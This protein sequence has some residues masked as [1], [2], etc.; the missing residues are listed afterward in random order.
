MS[1]KLSRLQRKA[2]R[3]AMS[4]VDKSF[5]S[6]LAVHVRA[7]DKALAEANSDFL[8]AEQKIKDER[9]VARKAAWDT[10]EEERDKLVKKYGEQEVA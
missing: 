8:A 2:R 4:T 9:T 5:N 6:E 7:R 3:L 10:Y 1:Q